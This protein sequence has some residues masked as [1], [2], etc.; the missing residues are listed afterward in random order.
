M[1]SLRVRQ[2][3]LIA[4]GLLSPYKNNDENHQDMTKMALDRLTSS[5]HEIGHTIGLA[6]NFAASTND[7]SSVMDYPHPYVTLNQDGSM[8]FTK[9]YD[10]KIGIWSKRAIM[11]GYATYKNENEEK[12]GLNKIINE[13]HNMG[14]RFLTDEDARSLEVLLL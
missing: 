10:N 8:N 11:Y 7:L 13:N 9:A 2:D 12:D 5:A 4:Q 14:L 6:H 1:G 3:F